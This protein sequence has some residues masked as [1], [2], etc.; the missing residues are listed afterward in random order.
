MANIEVAKTERV[1]IGQADSCFTTADSQNGYPETRKRLAGYDDAMLQREYLAEQR[2]GFN[3]MF[4]HNS[5]AFCNLLAD[6]L[7]ARGITH[8][9]NIFGAIEVRR[10]TY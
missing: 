7:I 6:E 5:R 1:Y 10:W 3:K 8:I 4:G 9:P 2:H